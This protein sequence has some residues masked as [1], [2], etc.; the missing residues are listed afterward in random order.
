VGLVTDGKYGPKTNAKLKELGYN[1][2]SDADVDKICNKQSSPEK[3][4]TPEISGE[5]ITS[6]STDL[7]F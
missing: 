5:E 4:E 7:N 2:F 3:P 6:D 1:S